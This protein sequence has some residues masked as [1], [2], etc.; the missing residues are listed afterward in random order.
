MMLGF[1]QGG[2]SSSSWAGGR[3][4]RGWKGWHPFFFLR[5]G[6]G[7]KEKRETCPVELAKGVWPASIR[8]NAVAAER[9][10]LINA[11]RSSCNA[12]CGVRSIGRS[13]CV[14]VYCT[15]EIRGAM[16]VARES[17]LQ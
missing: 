6:P 7:R 13:V 5:D 3:H 14:V 11:M 4:L 8:V 10:A 1:L 12:C 16:R 9:H 15:Y 17:D 2:L